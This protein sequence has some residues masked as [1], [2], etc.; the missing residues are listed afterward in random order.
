MGINDGK[1]GVTDQPLTFELKLGVVNR[2]QNPNP[3]NW[4]VEIS[5]LSGSVISFD[6]PAGGTFSITPNEEFAHVR[7]YVLD[8]SP[9]GPRP[10]DN[11]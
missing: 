7:V 1:M 4:K 9:L 5:T 6:V 10:V 8:V 3:S 11:D 2:I